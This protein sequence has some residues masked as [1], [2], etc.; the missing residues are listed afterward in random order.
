[1][2]LLFQLSHHLRHDDQLAARLGHGLDL[3]EAVGT[4][5][6]FFGGCR[7]EVGVVGDLLQFHHD[8]EERR[9]SSGLG[10]EGLEVV[11]LVSV[12]KKFV[13]FVTKLSRKNKPSLASLFRQSPIFVGK[14][15]KK[16]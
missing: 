10:P 2:A 8:V 15:S 6:G 16:P 1:M 12:L 14:V 3:E 7:K 9:L 13:F 4:N 11:G 5:R